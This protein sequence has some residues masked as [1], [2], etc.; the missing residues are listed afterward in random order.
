MDG[1][2]FQIQDNNNNNNNTNNTEKRKEEEKIKLAE[3][4]YKLDDNDVSNDHIVINPR[5]KPNK[6]KNRNVSICFATMCKNEEHCIRDTLENVYKHIDYW[7]VSDT[8]STDNTCKIITEFFEEKNIPGELHHDEWVGFDKN[9]TKLFNYCY[10]KADYIL[11]LDADDLLEGDFEFR[12]EDAGK[13]KYYCLCRR[14]NS[15]TTYKVIFMFNNHYKWKFCGVAHTT[16]KCLDNHN[17]L[18]DGYLTDRN[19]YFNSRDTGNRSSDKEKYYKDALIL[20]EQFFNTLIDDPDDLNARS[21]FYTGQSYFDSGRLE[22]S[23]KWYLLYLK[24]KEENTWVEER[25]ECYMRVALIYRIL[26]YDHD[27][28]VYMYNGAINIFPDRAEP[29]LQLGTYYNQN[30][31]FD[32]SYKI[33]SKGKTLS[34]REIKDKYFLYVNDRCYGKYINDELA[35]ACYWLGKYEYS[36]SL[37]EEIINDPDFASQRERLELNLNFALDKINEKTKNSTNEEKPNNPNQPNQP[38]QQTNKNKQNKSSTKPNQTNQ[39]SNKN[40]QD[41]FIINI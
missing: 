14:G 33:L 15:S 1:F 40:E 4:V 24:L 23:A 26:K 10:K 6:N 39:T 31:L 34:L 21:V 22:D 36:K 2:N 8:G 25:F 5:L 9:K 27:R 12:D 41:P 38:N 19:F 20:T 29:Y 28:I 17:K 11:H 16:I 37:I 13:L 7:V 30:R 3:N 32:Q 18:P 35:V